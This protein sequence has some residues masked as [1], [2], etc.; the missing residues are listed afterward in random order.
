MRYFKMIV[1]IM[2]CGLFTVSCCCFFPYG[3]ISR[4][5]AFP[6]NILPEGF[7]QSSEDILVLPVWDHAP[8]SV[9]EGGSK[10]NFDILGKAFFWPAKDLH[11]LPDKISPKTSFALISLPA[12]VGRWVEFERLYLISGNG[13]VLCLTASGT[14]PQLETKWGKIEETRIG[15]N[16]KKHL[17]EVFSSGDETELSV[18]GSNLFSNSSN[19]ILKIEYS[20]SARRDI[21]EFIEKIPVVGQHSY[22]E[23]WKTIYYSR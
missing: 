12:M 9:V 1:F 3:F 2:C 20:S 22:Q 17:I 11:E 13:Q 8:Y 10:R 6:D 15:S 23:Y 21:V 14:H 5:P 4:V 7:M 18:K 19:P 16:W